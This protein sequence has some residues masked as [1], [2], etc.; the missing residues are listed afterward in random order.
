MALGEP[1]HHEPAFGHARNE[2]FARLVECGFRSIV[3]ESDR[4][5]ALVVD[6]FVQDGVGSLDS[7]M[8]DGFSHWFGALEA[9]RDLVSWMREY[10]VGRPPEDRLAFHGMDAPLEFTA[11]SPRSDLEYVRDYL[12]RDDDI[13]SLAGDDERWSRTEAVS[14][15]AESPGETAE[16]MS[17]RAI[18][19]DMLTAL[20]AQAPALIAGSSLSTWRRAEIHATSALGL[21]RYHRQ[22]AQH[23]EDGARWSRLSGV[24][25]V[26]MARNL[27]DIRDV[28]SGRGPSLVFAHNIHLQRGQSR[29]RMAGMD[30]AWFGTGS[31]VASL[32]GERFA[33]I[34]SCMGPGDGLF[35]EGTVPDASSEPG[36]DRASSWRL[37][38]ADA[39]DPTVEPTDAASAK[40]YYSLDE[41][42]IDGAD[43]VLHVRKRT[44]SPA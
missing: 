24:R 14:D 7:A 1:A 35:T 27:L 16:A 2:V 20:Y 19:D 38:A 36:P 29:M 28:E 25:D 17:L 21:L 13:A 33:F 26:L 3:L 32:L 18:A 41:A 6:D 42:V 12:G 15:P 22:A 37:A 8:R 11:A 4:V 34:P 10:N 30:L 23:I 9:N 43:A 39:V 40:D 31:I 5:A 44:G